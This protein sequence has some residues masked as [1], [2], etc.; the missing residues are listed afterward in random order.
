[1]I[2]TEIL[3]KISKYR[4]FQNGYLMVMSAETLATT[5]VKI[6]KMYAFSQLKHNDIHVHGKLSKIDFFFFC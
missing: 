3:S 2:K 5:E 4:F 6:A 1:M